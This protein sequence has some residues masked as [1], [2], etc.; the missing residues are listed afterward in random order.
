MKLDA[1][2]PAGPLAAKWDKYRADAKLVVIDGMNLLLKSAS[3][4]LAAQRASFADP[5]LPIAPAL[6]DAV[7]DFVAKPEGRGASSGP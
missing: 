1:K 6:V 7:A 2:I 4:D 5:A 3:G